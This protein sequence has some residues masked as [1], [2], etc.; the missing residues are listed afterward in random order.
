MA[1]LM[2]SLDRGPMLRGVARYRAG[3]VEGFHGGAGGLKRSRQRP[4]RDVRI[5]DDREPRL[6]GVACAVRWPPR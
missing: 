5:Q 1:K 6:R 3:E 4:V 2:A